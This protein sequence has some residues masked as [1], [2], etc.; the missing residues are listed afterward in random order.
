M[1]CLEC[2]APLTPSR[3]GA[4]KRFC[5]AVCKRVF[6]ERARARGAYL[7]H[8]VRA[9]RR[10]RKVADAL[11]LQNAICRLEL[12]FNDQDAGKRTWLPPEMALDDI[13]RMDMMPSTNLYLPREA[14]E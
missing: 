14:A 6:R 2:S 9:W 1:P 12:Y 4:P 3:R 8:L 10:E 11:G 7:Y 5:S 13:Q